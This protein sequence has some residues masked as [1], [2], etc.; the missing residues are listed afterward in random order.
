MSKNAAKGAQPVSA[1]IR[2]K[3]VEPFILA[4]RTVLG[5]MASADVV[6]RA[7]CQNPDDRAAGDLAVM[8]RLTSATLALLVLS[9]PTRTAAALARRMLADVAAE[10]DEPLIRECIG[11]I[12]NVVAGQAK[13]LLASTPYHYTF[14][15]P[16]V[17]DDV[18][19]F[20]PASKPNCLVIDFNGEQG[21]FALNLF[22]KL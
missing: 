19:N 15:L 16:E 14:S 22:L 13:A 11:E 3:L 1:E 7:V 5:E 17:V 9:F 10:I 20:Q 21:E 4:T 12:G 6:V 2:D 18:I 8:L